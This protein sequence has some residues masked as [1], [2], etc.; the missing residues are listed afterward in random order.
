M[1]SREY[2]AIDEKVAAETKRLKKEHPNLGHEGLMD[3]LDQQGIVLDEAD[4]KDYVRKHKLAPGIIQQSWGWVASR[5]I[6]P[7]GLFHRGPPENRASRRVL[8]RKRHE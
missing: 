8:W 3:A 6:P 1:T 2:D 5:W 7:F 4:F